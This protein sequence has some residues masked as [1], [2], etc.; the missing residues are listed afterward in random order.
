MSLVRKDWYWIMKALLLSVLVGCMGVAP[1]YNQDAGDGELCCALTN[2]YS[3]A[4]IWTGKVYQC[5]DIGQTIT[6]LPWLCFNGDS[7]AL[8]CSSSECEVGNACQG[9]NGTGVVIYCST[10]GGE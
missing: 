8:A 6:S 7:G 4:S 9:F 5:G 3:D 1:H 10:V 2:N